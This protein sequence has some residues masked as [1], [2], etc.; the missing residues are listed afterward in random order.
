M[1]LL[2]LRRRRRRASLEGYLLGS[3]LLLELLALLPWEARVL[4]LLRLR[5][6]SEA[7]RLAREASKLLLHWLHWPSSEARR[8]RCQSALEAAGLLEG[9]LLLL[10]PIL[11]LPRS[12]TVPTP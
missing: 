1:L 11:R 10:L 7:L 4:R 6:L 3:L 9:L 8:L 5:L 2:L 12:G